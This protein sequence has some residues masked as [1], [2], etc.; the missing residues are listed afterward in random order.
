MHIQLQIGKYTEPIPFT[1][2]RDDPPGVTLQQVGLKLQDVWTVAMLGGFDRFPNGLRDDLWTAIIEVSTCA[3]RW[4]AGGGTGPTFSQ[5]TIC[6]G[7]AGEW[8]LDL[9]SDAGW[10]L[11]E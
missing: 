10:N 5:K 8:R 2:E 9:D 3:A 1:M 6:Q 7:K 11:R 4:R